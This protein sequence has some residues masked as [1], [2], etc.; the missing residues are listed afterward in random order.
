M[1][2]FQ[3]AVGI[4]SAQLERQLR[5]RIEHLLLSYVPTRRKLFEVRLQQLEQA[6]LCSAGEQSFFDQSVYSR[7]F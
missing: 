4:V 2:A 5:D 1:H 3:D 7:C 6:L